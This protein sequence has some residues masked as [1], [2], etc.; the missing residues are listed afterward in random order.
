MAITAHRPT[1]PLTDPAKVTGVTSADAAATGAVTPPP[2][3]VGSSRPRWLVPT[4][5]GL[6]VLLVALLVLAVIFGAR[7]VSG[8]GV[9]QGRAAALATGRQAAVNLTSFDFTT[10]EADV[11]RLRDSTTPNFEN[12]FATDKD[13]FVKF[14]RDGKVKMTSNVT[15][16]GLL[17]YSGSAAHVLVAVKSQVSNNQTPA[18]EARNYRMDVS[19]VY[20]DGRWLAN[21]AEFIS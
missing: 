5:V 12:G 4:A 2:D 11:Q 7:T 13:A 6:G 16:A 8:F 17:S 20:Q 10:A 19:M 21:G 3:G 15:E 18:P 1:G 14:L 9:E